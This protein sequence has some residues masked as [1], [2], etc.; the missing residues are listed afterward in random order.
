[1]VTVTLAFAGSIQ[2]CKTRTDNRNSKIRATFLPEPVLSLGRRCGWRAQVK[3][4]RGRWWP[5]AAR[6][7]PVQSVVILTVILDVVH[8]AIFAGFEHRYLPQPSNRRCTWL[9]VPMN[10]AFGVDKRHSLSNLH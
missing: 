3:D 8:A 2:F 1:M 10:D 5:L 9:Q 4:H 7:L 6:C